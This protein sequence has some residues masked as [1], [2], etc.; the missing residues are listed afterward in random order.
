MSS[1]FPDVVPRR[2]PSPYSQ[3]MNRDDLKK[4]P[5]NEEISRCIEDQNGRCYVG[6]CKNGVTVFAVAYGS[7][8]GKRKILGFCGN[9]SP[10]RGQGIQAKA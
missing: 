7:F 10:E 8:D 4:I 1:R 2:I 6:E 9:H 5:S 3:G